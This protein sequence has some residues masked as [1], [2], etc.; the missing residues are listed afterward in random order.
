MAW[1]FLKEKQMVR[2]SET[3]DYVGAITLFVGLSCLLLFL[4]ICG[5]SGFTSPFILSIGLVSFIFLLFFFIQEYRVTQPVIDLKLYRKP[6][7]TEGSIHLFIFG[8]VS[9]TQFFLM[10]LKYILSVILI[11]FVQVKYLS[12][13]I[14]LLMGMVCFMPFC[15][16]SHVSGW[17]SRLSSMVTVFLKLNV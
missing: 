3:L 4:N 13:L 16:L 14:E 17:N 15:I 8:L 7:F 6:L 10:V 9:S 5:R 11:E 2:K 1:L 12:S